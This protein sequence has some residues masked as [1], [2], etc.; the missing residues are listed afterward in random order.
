MSPVLLRPIREQ[1]EHNRVIRLLQGR[2][3]RRYSVAT[4]IGDEPEATGVRLRGAEVFPDLILTGTK[5]PR[6]LHG[7]IEVETAES[8]NRLEA[9]A[10]WVPFAKIRGAFYLYVPAG[11][12]DIAKRLCEQHLVPVTEI[13]SYHPVGEQIRFTMSH[14]SIRLSRVRRSK[15]T[16]DSLR[17]AQRAAPSRKGKTSKRSAAKAVKPSAGK[18][19]A[20]KPSAR[21]AVSRKSTLAS[22]LASPRGQR[23]K[24]A[25]GRAPSRVTTLVAKVKTFVKK[26]APGKPSKRR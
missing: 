19:K 15:E 6:R 2:F 20:V 16:G 22:G 3:R 10:E 25:E 5:S 21:K 17:S 13:W 7:V 1:I 8:V 12:A 18:A 11:T 4:N 9:M 23:V 26:A 14:R 24:K